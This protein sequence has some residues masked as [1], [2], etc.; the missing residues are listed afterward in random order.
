MAIDPVTL[1]AL[2]DLVATVL[3][4]LQ[5]RFTE[6]LKQS[7][8]NASQSIQRDEGL[9]HLLANTLDLLS[10][11]G[12]F[13]SDDASVKVTSDESSDLNRS[14]TSTEKSAVKPIIEAKY[15][16]NHLSVPVS[17]VDNLSEFADLL[18]SDQLRLH[19]LGRAA[20]SAYPEAILVR[21]LQA[22][23]EQIGKDVGGLR[24]VT[25]TI[26]L[27]RSREL[28]NAFDRALETVLRESGL[29][30]AV[31]KC[32]TDFTVDHNH[33]E[34]LAS[35]LA[36]AVV[37]MG[38]FSS[39]NGES[40]PGVRLDATRSGDVLR[41][42]MSYIRDPF[43]DVTRALDL[44][45]YADIFDEF[46]AI[47]YIEGGDLEALVVEMPAS[48]KNMKGIVVKCGDKT[49]ALPAHGI[50]ETLRI[51]SSKVQNIDG[52]EYLNLRASSLPLIP[53]AAIFGD[54]ERDMSNVSVNTDRLKY[55]LI[56]QSG[57][58]RFGLTVDELVQHR[59]LA[60]RPLGGSLARR[61]TV[62]GGA[63]DSDGSI[64]LVL[65]PRQV[66]PVVEKG[67]A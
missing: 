56:I 41:F 21:Q 49:Y 33:V 2:E 62:M 59:E 19:A 26:L 30:V 27:R 66:R 14:V 48:L 13:L 15:S 51:D 42:S 47:V 52:Q 61:R 67:A 25:E 24:R 58:R 9:C 34:E 28:E 36:G 60:V 16:R 37:A 43:G 23:A 44:N 22:L 64:I 54:A 4:E 38:I 11:V 6:V 1:T 40:K 57:G 29:Q 8:S 3:P 31:E 35:A 7:E 32:F 39:A 17:T 10:V 55:V 65:D 46:K 45:Q 53:L 50:I 63:I 5:Q 20:L 18:E 12:V